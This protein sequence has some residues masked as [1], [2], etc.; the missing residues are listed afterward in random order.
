LNE[1]ES[2]HQQ[3]PQFYTALY[4]AVAAA[5][6]E[7]QPELKIV[8]MALAYHREWP[9][10]FYF[11]NQSNHA[12]GIPLDYVSFHFY[13]SV[14]SRTDPN[15]YE[16]FFPQCDDF[17]EEVAQIIVIRDQLSPS[18]QLFIDEVGVILP[19]DT[20]PDPASFPLVYWNAAAAEFAYLFGNLAGQNVSWLGMSQL[21]GYPTQFPSVS[22]VNWTTGEMTPRYFTLKLLLEHYRGGAGAVYPTYVNV[23][24]VFAQGFANPT[25]TLLLVNKQN[26][27]QAVGLTADWQNAK[28]ECVDENSGFSPA[29]VKVLTDHTNLPLLPYAVCVVTYPQQSN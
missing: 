24:G 22:M 19:D 29:P 6:L 7:V 25:Q 9:W 14:P 17:I 23:D 28:Y 20:A 26:G 3:S 8:G 18:T 10:W 21:V 13:A 1:V 27:A 12:S 16:A 4:D 15:G 2:E 11:L 5:M